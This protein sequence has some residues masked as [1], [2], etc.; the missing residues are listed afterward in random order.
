MSYLSLS[1]LLLIFL[2][3]AF[4]FT[5]IEGGLY[6]SNILSF[7]LFV[8]IIINLTPK[9]LYNERNKFV[10]LVG[11]SFLII[12]NM[13][14]VSGIKWLYLFLMFYAYSL[15]F[16]YHKY[17]LNHILFVYAFGIV[18]GTLLSFQFVD[19]SDLGYR[20]I[21]PDFRGSISQLGGFNTY[22]VL[23]AYAMLILIHLQTQYKKNTFKIFS[24]IGLTI[25]FIAE[26]STLSRGGFLSLIFGLSTYSY[27]KGNLLKNTLIFLTLGGIIVYLLVNNLG[28]DFT[29]VFNRY[30]FYEDT[31]G[32]G[33]TVLWSHILSLMSNPFVIIFGN[34]AGS[35]DLYLSLAGTLTDRGWYNE[36]ESTHNTYLEFFWQFGLIGLSL[37]ITFLYQT[38]KRIDQI[39]LFENQIILKT[40]FYVTLLNMFFDSYFFA[41]QITAIYSLFFSLFRE[42]RNA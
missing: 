38:K 24:F 10:W 20:I 11:L 34:G 3:L 18:V 2:S 15:F 23:A 4:N 8:L 19:F 25:L 7:I 32:T 33:R 36:F 31:T 28:L 30:S 9:Q 17:N 22:G 26:I 27:F 21:D 16:K 6:F 42:I 29:T 35:L 1:F 12:I 14:S 41:I 5:L 39:K 40:L 37:F 13:Q